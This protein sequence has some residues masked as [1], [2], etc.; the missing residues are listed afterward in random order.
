MSTDRFVD[1]GG[2][3]IEVGDTARGRGVILANGTAEIFMH[4]SVEQLRCL[5]AVIYSRMHVH[6]LHAGATPEVISWTVT[7]LNVPR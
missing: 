6:A 1:Y 5:G 3:L 7:E 4:A 2:Q